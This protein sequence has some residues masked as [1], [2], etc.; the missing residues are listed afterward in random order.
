[1]ATTSASIMFGKMA[2]KKVQ[3]RT[4]TKGETEDWIAVL[5]AYCDD[6]DEQV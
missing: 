6:G 5:T 3:V 4:L 2:T 1:V